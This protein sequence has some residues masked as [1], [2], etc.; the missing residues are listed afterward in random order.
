MDL[1]RFLNLT[2][3]SKVKCKVL[4]PVLGNPEYKCRLGRER[5]ESSP[6]EKVLGLFTKTNMTWPCAVTIQKASCNVGCKK[7]V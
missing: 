7:A 5:V 6:E 3:F 1:D 2:E 4:H